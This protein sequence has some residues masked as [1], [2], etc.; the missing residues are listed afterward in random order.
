MGFAIPVDSFSGTPPWFPPLGFSLLIR[1]CGTTYFP[2][3]DLLYFYFLGELH[4]SPK[5]KI[6]YVTLDPV[7]DYVYISDLN[8]RLLVG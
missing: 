2:V 6:A 3:G 7:S 1:S 4:Q 5:D 8:T